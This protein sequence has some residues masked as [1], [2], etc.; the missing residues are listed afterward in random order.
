MDPE[1][2]IM[3]DV[4]GGLPLKA[5]LPMSRGGVRLLAGPLAPV[6]VFEVLAGPAGF[7]RPSVSTLWFIG[8]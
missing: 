7:R 2:R 1:R 8:T 5:V 6:D 3:E 4:S